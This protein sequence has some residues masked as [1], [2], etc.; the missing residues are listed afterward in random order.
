MNKLK[1][2]FNLRLYLEGLKKLKVLGIATSIIVV[3]LSALVPVIYM[4]TESETR[5][6]GVRP[7]YDVQINEFAIPL[8][9]LLLFAPFFVSSIF[10]YLNHR[11]ESDF[12][13]AIPYKRACVFNS[14]MLAAFSWVLGIIIASVGVCGILWGIAPYA[15]YSV[16]F[17]PLIIIATF[18]AC[19]LLMCF[20]ALAMSLT[21]TSASNLFIFCLLAFFARVAFA[22]FSMTVEST[23]FIWDAGDTL[24][25][26]IEPQFFFPFALLGATVEV[27]ETSEVYTN[28]AL[29]IYTYAVCIVL[30]L[31]AA[32]VY[33]KRRS[34]MAGKSAPSKKLQHVYR[35]AFA[36]PFGL[37]LSSIM[38][39]DVFGKSSIADSASYVILI[40]MVLFVYFFYEL[41]TTRSPKSMLKATPYLIILIAIC[42]LY[43]VGVGCIRNVV[44]SKA[45]EASEISS[46][47]FESEKS[48]MNDKKTYE[49]IMCRSVEIRDRD[50]IE[51]VAQA[52][53]F[54]IE[55]AKD[56]SF[57]RAHEVIDRDY[58]TENGGIE[59]TY[60]AE[61]RSFSFTKVKINLK[62]GQSISRNI[63]MYEE[64]YAELMK[65]AKATEEYGE[66]Y[67][68]I[69][70]PEQ[71]YSDSGVSSYEVSQFNIDR[72]KLYECY[73]NEYMS[74]SNDGKIAVKDSNGFSRSLSLLG[75]EG[76]ESFIFHA[77]FTV[78]MPKTMQ[79]FREMFM[80]AESEGSSIVGKESITTEEAVEKVFSEYSSIM[81]GNKS[82]YIQLSIHVYD[83]AGKQIGY[84]DNNANDH[85]TQYSKGETVIKTVTEHSGELSD[86]SYIVYIQIHYDNNAAG[87]QY[88]YI[89]VYPIYFI[90]EK[91]MDGILDAINLFSDMGDDYVEYKDYVVYE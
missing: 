56:G 38:S 19:L 17:L 44:F 28:P 40:V 87:S 3:G 57:E 53:V 42:S 67:L 65:K 30:Y 88:E 24:G 4:I 91:Y 12:Y 70:R 36:L 9:L 31:L 43:I 77:K 25:M 80:A 49:E 20:M 27:F 60:K 84:L 74:L 58:R 11:N 66:A 89:N 59:Y 46:V 10:S 48:Y 62:N 6:S 18:T 26:L 78:D 79:M 5:Y 64:D 29:Y 2:M 45:P 54:S 76:L 15:S 34:E 50:V 33:S 71:I 90:D 75:R 16:G 39:I 69:P 21:G 52:L 72:K 37:I 41:I 7:I 86:S 68:A 1:N 23:V 14:F 51:D 81:I 85:Q 55:K 35:I 13:H 32:L 82:K 8:A 73:Y 63:K 47:A 22:L 61:A 83:P